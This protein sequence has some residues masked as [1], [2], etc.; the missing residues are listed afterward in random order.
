[1]QAAPKDDFPTGPV[2]S[3]SAP[4]IASNGEFT[5]ARYF[6]GGVEV[7]SVGSSRGVVSRSYDVS[8]A[9]SFSYVGLRLLPERPRILN[10]DA[11]L[12][13]E[14]RKWANSDDNY[15]LSTRPPLV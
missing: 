10:N 7:D 12:H 3:G 1:V 2:S 9:P 13:I 14:R 15:S 11:D 6:G 5:S 8:A 4:L